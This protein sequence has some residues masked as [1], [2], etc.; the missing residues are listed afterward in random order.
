MF[1]G[2]STGR[3]MIRIALFGYGGVCLKTATCLA[4]AAQ[5]GHARAESMSFE[6]VHPD[7]NL[8][9]SR[10]R[11]LGAAINNVADQ[12]DVLV[13][14]D[15]DMT[16]GP[17][18]IHDLASDSLDVAGPVGVVAPRKGHGAGLAGKLLGEDIYRLAIPSAN[19]REAVVAGTGIMAIPI[20]KMIEIIERGKAPPL[21]KEEGNAF[22]AWF[23]P[24]I[25]M[26][27]NMEHGVI[28]STD[29]AF[30]W[31]VRNAGGKVYISFRHKVGHIGDCEFGAWDE[32][33]KGNITVEGT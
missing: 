21:I 5:H 28:L 15:R 16:F 10:S 31:R 30:C 13:M 22:H 8:G 29:A 4:R 17:G 14:I 9:R 26:H 1:F 3:S 25:A 12:N 20:G 32:A 2:Q 19:V 23:V 18:V 24:E 6:D 7:A 33:L 27:P 11:V